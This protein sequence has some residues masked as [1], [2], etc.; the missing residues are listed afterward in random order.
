MGT[1]SIF[2]SKTFWGA[3]M[4][5]ASVVLKAAATDGIS[6]AVLVEALGIILGAVGIRSAIAKNGANQ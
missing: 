5:A 3:V 6:A 4:L 2:R 1:F